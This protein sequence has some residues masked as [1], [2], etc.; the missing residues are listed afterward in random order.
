MIPFSLPRTFGKMVGN[1]RQGYA[2]VAA[3]GIIWLGFVVAD[4]VDRVRP[5]RAPRSQVA[6][7][8]MEGKETALRRSAP[9]RCS[10]CPPR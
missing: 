4:D 10:R 8:A 7:G 5:P 6:G 3:M 2:I 1:V 9:R